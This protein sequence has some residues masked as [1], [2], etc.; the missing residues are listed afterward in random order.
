MSTNLYIRPFISLF[1]LCATLSVFASEIYVYPSPSGKKSTKAAHLFILSG[2]SNMSFFNAKDYFAPSIKEI[3]G[4]ESVII[5]KDAKGGQSIQRWYKDW[6]SAQGNESKYKGDLYDRLMSNVKPAI[7]GREIKTITFIWMQ[8]ESDAAHNQVVGVYK[9]SLKG[10]FK[11]LETDLG[12]TDINYIIGRVSDYTL[13]P[14]KNYQKHPQ[15][16]A[17]RDIQVNFAKEHPRA[18]WVNCDDLNNI[19]DKATG[20]PFNG[21]HYT[22]EGYET[23]GKRYVEKAV[24]MIEKFFNIR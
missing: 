1:L 9:E 16:Q 6:K 22:Q 20:I 3:Y 11:Q 14:G 2:Q 15:W 23:L 13:E 19:T 18:T 17:L 10:L 7:E 24:Q 21:V 12:R 8:G 4:E 5:V